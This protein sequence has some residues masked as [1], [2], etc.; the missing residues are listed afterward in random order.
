MMSLESLKELAEQGDLSA[1]YNLGVAYALRNASPDDAQE[2]LKW[3][4]LAGKQGHK[5]A[6][7]NLGHT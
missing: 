7:Y 5:L 3:W 1:Q 6:Q 4:V 2:A